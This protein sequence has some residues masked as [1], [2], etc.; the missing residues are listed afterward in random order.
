MTLGLTQGER[1]FEALFGLEGKALDRRPACQ[2]LLCRMAH[3][4]DDN[5]PLAATAS[6]KPSH[7]LGALLRAASGLALECGG[8]VSARRDYVVDDR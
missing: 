5:M 4:L 2:E 8:P 3:Q 1:L 6:A 7:D